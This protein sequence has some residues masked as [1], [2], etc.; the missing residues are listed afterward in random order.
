MSPGIKSPL[1][2]LLKPF[3]L[4][5]NTLHSYLTVFLKE[6]GKSNDQGADNDQ[7]VSNNQGADNDQG[8]SNNQGASGDQGKSNDQDLSNGEDE[9]IYLSFTIAFR[10]KYVVEAADTTDITIISV[11]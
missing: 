2:S 5:T 1:L 10:D 4:F 9:A 6:Q 11:A 7:G 8:V 3:S